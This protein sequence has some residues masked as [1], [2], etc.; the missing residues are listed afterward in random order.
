MLGVKGLGLLSLCLVLPRSPWLESRRRCKLWRSFT[1]STCPDSGDE[2][3]AAG[4]SISLN[5]VNL[6]GLSSV[7]L[8]NQLSVAVV[9]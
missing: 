9:T 8:L 4:L 3:T 1:V 7:L 6:L 2:I 5:D